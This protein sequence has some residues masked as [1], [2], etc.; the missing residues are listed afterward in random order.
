MFCYRSLVIMENNVYTFNNKTY[1]LKDAEDVHQ[2]LEIF[3]TSPVTDDS[4]Q[5]TLNE[6]NVAIGN[7]EET[8]NNEDQTGGDIEVID[9]DGD[10]GGGVGGGD[11]IILGRIFFIISDELEVI[12]IVDNLILTPLSTSVT[13]IP[14]AFEGLL[15]REGSSTNIRSSSMTLS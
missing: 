4:K 15:R 13:E 10:D 5:K 14:L 2:L 12:D 11:L 1:N 8:N 7:L 9:I 3:M 6:L